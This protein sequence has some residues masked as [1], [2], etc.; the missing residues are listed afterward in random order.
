[1]ARVSG[2]PYEIDLGEAEESVIELL[3]K[4]IE[5]NAKDFVYL[6]TFEIFELGFKIGFN[7]QVDSKEQ[8]EFHKLKE[9]VQ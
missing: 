6:N 1:M 4:E 2:V 5:N 3:K 9:D 7:V 8:T